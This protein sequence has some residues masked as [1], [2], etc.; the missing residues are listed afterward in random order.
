MLPFGILYLAYLH[1]TF[2]ARECLEITPIHCRLQPHL[3]A[4]GALKEALR[5]RPTDEAAAV[6]A[7]QS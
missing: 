3:E 4:E 2:G 5:L 6:S 1:P 7:D